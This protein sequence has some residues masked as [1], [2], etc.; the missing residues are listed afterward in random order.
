MISRLESL[1]G[2]GWVI[3]TAMRASIGDIQRFKDG[4]V[5]ASWL[6]FTPKEHSSG[7]T[8]TLGRMSK[9][10]DVYCRTLLIQGARAVLAA[11]KR[12]QVAGK[13]MD[14]L[15]SW[16]VRS[17]SV[18]ASTR[19][20][21]HWPTNLRASSGPHGITIAASTPTTRHASIRRCRCAPPS[22]D[23]RKRSVNS[24]F[25]FTRQTRQR[26]DQIKL[27]TS[28][29]ARCGKADNY[30]DLRGRLNDRPRTCEFH[31][32]PGG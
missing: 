24:P 20:Q 31:D 10:G 15:R 9:R 26:I 4:R 27:I 3:A 5:L 17:P 23:Q 25:L 18:A 12:A 7:S 22:P 28:G 19:L 6:G 21:S 1:P 11:A 14:R 2:I 30:S 13:P 29:S 32:V 16:A 8:R